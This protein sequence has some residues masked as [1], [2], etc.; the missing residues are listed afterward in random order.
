MKDDL[1]GFSRRFFV[2][3]NG[4]G[5]AGF[6]RRFRSTLKENVEGL[7]EEGEGFTWTSFSFSD[8]SKSSE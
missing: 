7:E 4:G 3:F 8:P 1:P 6:G 2:G 5:C